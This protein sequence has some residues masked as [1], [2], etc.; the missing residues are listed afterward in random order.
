MRRGA[1]NARRRS[2]GRDTVAGIGRAALAELLG[3]YAL[4]TLAAGAVVLT[5]APGTEGTLGLLGVAS[6]HGV[7]Y[8]VLVTIFG[9]ISGG[10]LNPAVTLGVWAGGKVGTGRGLT[11]IAAQLV[12]GVLAGLTVR[13]FFLTEQWAPSNLGTPAL[14]PGVSIGRAILIEAVLTFFLVIAVW[15]TGLDPRGAKVG[16]FGIGLTVFVDILVGG[17]LTGAAMNPARHFGPALASGFW[18][19]W[20]VYWLGPMAGGAVAGLVYRGVFWEE[21]GPEPPAAEARMARAA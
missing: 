17:P 6:A 19:D 2:E 8:A 7:A 13:A 15:G 10:H 4:V 14:G 9:G 12:G 21:E 3:T 1:T 5:T 20:W 11:Y 16:G 18:T